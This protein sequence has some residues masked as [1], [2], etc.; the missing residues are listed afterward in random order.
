[1]ENIFARY[2]CSCYTGLLRPVLPYI[3]AYQMDV[4]LV[5]QTTHNQVFDCAVEY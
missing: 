4:T 1:M 3:A 2:A 5:E